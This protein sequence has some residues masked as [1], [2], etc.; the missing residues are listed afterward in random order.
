MVLVIPNASVESSRYDDLLSE[1]LSY[2]DNPDDC[3]DEDVG[4]YPG[5]NKEQGF[6]CVLDSDGDG[7][8]WF[9]PPL[10]YDPGTDCN[11]ARWFSYQPR[12]TRSL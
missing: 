6:V 7:L 1:G 3:N 12:S 10:P 2:V 8:W 5:R 4:V 11:D 9:D